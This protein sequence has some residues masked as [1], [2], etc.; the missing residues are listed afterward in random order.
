MLFQAVDIVFAAHHDA[1]LRAAEQFVAR[2]ADQVAT[3]GKRF[4]HRG[5]GVFAEHIEVHEGARALILVDEQLGAV[6]A[7]GGASGVLR[8]GDVA[9]V[10]L[11]DAFGEADHAV[12]GGVHLEQHGRIRRDGALVIKGVRLVRGAH[13]HHAGVR[14]RHDVR[15][16]EAAADLDELASADDGFVAGGEL[17]EHHHD[18]CRV[19]VHGD[20]GLGA[21]KR[22]DEVFHMVVAAAAR[23]VLDAVFERGVAARR[24]H[25]GLYGGLCQHAAAEVGV[26]DHAGCV[27]DAPEARAQRGQRAVDGIGQDG[28]CVDRIHCSRQ[29]ELALPVYRRTGAFDEH[30]AGDDGLERLHGSGLHQLFDLGQCA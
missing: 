16:A 26:N 9:K 22:A 30:G 27:D 20:G 12:V 7:R 5:L 24:L 23:H 28:L 2:E 21:G 13:L 11:R 19:V 17:G 3:F 8:I 25:H 15:Y 14:L 4:A 1:C 29:D 10:G 6:F 18:G